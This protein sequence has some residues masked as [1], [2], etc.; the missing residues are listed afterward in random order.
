MLRLDWLLLF[1]PRS[2]RGFTRAGCR[3]RFHALIHP[4]TS[5]VLALFAVPSA[6]QAIVLFG[7]LELFSQDDSGVRIIDNIFFKIEFVFEDM[8]NDSA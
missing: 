7:I 3:L 5:L 4:L 2:R 1:F 6:E 8:V